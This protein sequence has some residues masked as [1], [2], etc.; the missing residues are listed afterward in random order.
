[1]PRFSQ[2]N[3]A[4]LKT[5]M[6]SRAPDFFF[7]QD[8]VDLIMKTT[9]MKQDQILQWACQLRWKIKSGNIPGDMSVD[10]YLKASSSFLE[11]KVRFSELAI[12]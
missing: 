8:D 3:D 10:Q 11:Q 6:I 9:G 1:M 2:A 5:T 4:F 7:T 12:I